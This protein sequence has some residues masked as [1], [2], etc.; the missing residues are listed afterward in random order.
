MSADRPTASGLRASTG[1]QCRPSAPMLA[2]G[3]PA[4]SGSR[5]R[6]LTVRRH[7]LVIRLSS[8][9]LQ[10]ASLAQQR[11]QVTHWA[12]VAQLVR[13][14][15]RAHALDL[16]LGDVEDQHADQ[17]ALAVEE[18]RPG[19]PVDLLAARGEAKR[20]PARSPPISVRATSGRRWTAACGWRPVVRV[21]V[22]A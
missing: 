3:A 14:V 18:Q 10:L 20:V 17:P 5:R 21:K 11:A 2:G 12:Q 13:I 15:D 7:L 8:R 19:L 9:E 4:G 16:G 6:A 22:R 1:S